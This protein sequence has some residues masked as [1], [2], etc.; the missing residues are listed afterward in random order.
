MI[1][2]LDMPHGQSGELTGVWDVRLDAA[3]VSCKYTPYLTLPATSL[4][5]VHC[6]EIG[7]AYELSRTTSTS[8]GGDQSS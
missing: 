5:D 4:C 8:G 1:L 2:W 3:H 7:P 6:G